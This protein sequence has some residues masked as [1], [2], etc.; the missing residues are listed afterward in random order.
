MTKFDIK[1]ANNNETIDGFFL[2]T[3][4]SQEKTVTEK[5]F[6]NIILTNKN[7][8][9]SCKL[10]DNT[11]DDFEFFSSNTIVKIRAVV[12]EYKGSKQLIIKK[13]KSSDE[14][15]IS[16]L[17]MTANINVDEC[18]DFI[19]SIIDDFE[20][21]TLRTICKILL[22]DN[23][24][25]IKKIGAAKMH[26]HSVV[27]G[28]LEHTSTMLRNGIALI[29]S[30]DNNINKELLFSGIILHDIGK[31]KEFKC[32]DYG[33]IEDYT[34]EGELLGHITLG[35][36]MITECMVK[37]RYES[38]KEFDNNIVILLQHL[39]LTHHGQP[40]YGSPKYP[41][42]KEAELLSYLDM[43]DTKMNM[44]D[45]IISETDTNQFSQR[46]WALDNRKIFNRGN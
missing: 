7:G 13:Y 33:M 32:K 29:N 44:F 45:K 27:S 41:M 21:D 42:T 4:V 30:Y 12:N 40:E 28:W 18:Y 36:I 46:Q 16:E 38:R 43:L 5:P 25:K 35:I 17:V 37:L 1:K 3:S 26:H 11:E 34:V 39:L 23:E 20:N 22:T 9:I 2:V 24:N 8:E 10:W 15:D 6:L 31:L 14:T 19:F